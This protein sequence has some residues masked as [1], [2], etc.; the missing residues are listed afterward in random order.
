MSDVVDKAPIALFVY[1]RPAHTKATLDS[2]FRCEGSLES[3]LY[4]FCDGA[5]GLEDEAAVNEVRTLVRSKDWCK[6][7]HVI[8]RA[9]N[10]GLAE[11]I[12]NGVT[13]IVDRYGRVIVLEDDLILSS[14]FLNF[15]NDALET[16]KDIE[17]V[18]HISGYIFP[19]EG[20]LPETF[21]YRITTCWGWATWRRA[22]KFFE[23]DAKKSLLDVKSSGRS[24]E[25]D[26]DGYYQYV[27]ML[28]AQ[29]ESKLDSWATRWYA[30]VFL[31]EGL[32]LHPGLSL[33]NNIGLDSS[34]IHC[35]T[36]DIFEVEVNEKRIGD[37]THKIVED[38][39]ALELIKVFLKSTE[40]SLLAKMI[41]KAKTVM[42]RT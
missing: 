19:V 29:V 6:S 2:L 18:M 21:F 36:T 40:K 23:A 33:V 26:V 17:R 42:Q 13:K 22:W 39:E 28:E 1:N 9:E 10:L 27:K 12:I 7:V 4:I 31:K 16:Y 41:D 14:Q 8:E 30:S 32:C 3:E 35:G 15:M 38:E 37:F 25:F 11:S 24:D 34:G 5:K 20:E